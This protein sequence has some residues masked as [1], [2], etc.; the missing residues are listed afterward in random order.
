MPSQ[1]QAWCTQWP[2]PAPWANWR[3]AAVTKSG[4]GTRRPFALN[5]TVYN[6]R[7]STGG[8]VWCMA[9][10]STSLLTF[11]DPKTPG[12][13]AAAALMWNLAR[14][15][16]GTFWMP[17]KPTGTSM[18]VWGCITIELGDRWVE[19]EMEVRAY[20]CSHMYLFLYVCSL[21]VA[22]RTDRNIFSE[23]KILHIL[24]VIS[25]APESVSLIL[26]VVLSTI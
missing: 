20:G 16:Q 4:E 6:W 19:M 3:R 7:P 10:W 18:P 8:R 24:T 21:T 2:T 13:G 14:S 9:S 22:N 15:S 12:S 11:R 17:E 26:S 25:I 1:Q 23:R 5:C